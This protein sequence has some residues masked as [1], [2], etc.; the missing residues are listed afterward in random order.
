MPV[1]IQSVCEFLDRLAPVRLAEDWDNVGLLVGD[2]G[3]LARRIM[4]CL[5]IT[6]ESA[7]EAISRG[8]NLIVAH[9]PLPFR[10]LRRITTEATPSRILWNLIRHGIAV[11]SPHSGFDSAEDGINQRLAKKIGLRDSRPLVPDADKPES[12]G[13]GRIGTVIESQLLDEFA[14]R[15]K[16]EFQL[17]GLQVA[18]HPA[19]PVKTVAVS[20]GSGGTLLEAARLSGCDTFVT[21]E[22]SFHTCLEA[23]ANR[24]SVILL[25]HFSSERFAVE[26]LADDLQNQFS[27]IEVWASKKESDPLRWVL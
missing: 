7:D 17:P 8:A 11:Y 6:P 3:Q 2:P 5:T 9:H 24:I 4:I 13:T 23:V 18:G 16:R 21:G 15:I 14:G 22:T 19:T 20:C 12:L 26:H 25:G 1:E 10:P 27:E